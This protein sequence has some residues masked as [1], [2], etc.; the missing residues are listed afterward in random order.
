MKYILYI[1]YAKKSLDCECKDQF[2]SSE[3]TCV[4]IICDKNSVAVMVK[5]SS[6]RAKIRKVNKTCK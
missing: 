2:F 1:I 3:Q 4:S 6:L 5:K